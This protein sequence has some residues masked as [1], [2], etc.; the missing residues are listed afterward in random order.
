MSVLK[1]PPSPHV[2]L[3][4]GRN[5]VSRLVLHY[6]QDEGVRVDV[7]YEGEEVTEERIEAVKPDVGITCY[8]PRLLSVRSIAVP[9]YGWINFHPALLPQNRGWYPAVWEVMDDDQV[10]GVTLH[11]IDANADT[12]PVIAQSVFPVKETDTGGDVYER[13]QTAMV[14]LFIH[15]WPRL[16]EGVELQKQD[17]HIATYHTKR[18][19]NEAGEIKLNVWYTGDYLLRAIK[20]RTFGD[21]GYAWYRKNGKKYRVMLKVVEN[22]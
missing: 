15:T 17:N 18:E 13:S 5:T 8:W 16:R 7:I 1:L 4:A 10:A 22:E 20:A 12:G 2:L 11:V 6:L 21:M 14:D 19:T 9:K 3:L